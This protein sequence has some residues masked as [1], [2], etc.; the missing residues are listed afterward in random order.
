MG[1]GAACSP[2]RD[3]VGIVVADFTTDAA[4]SPP[5][6]LTD[7]GVPAEFQVVGRAL[8]NWP[9][10]IVDWP[11]TTP[12]HEFF[13]GD[14][15]NNAKHV[16]RVSGAMAAA[17]VDLWQRVEAGEFRASGD[18]VGVRDD[19]GGAYLVTLKAR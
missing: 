15:N 13:D 5:T 7:A 2:Q 16:V 3:V 8:E 17:L 18:V 9:F 12:L 19:A 14:P 10:P 1:L 6:L 4:D 11:L